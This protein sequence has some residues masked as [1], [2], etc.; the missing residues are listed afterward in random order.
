M[1]ICIIALLS[2]F[3]CGGPGETDNSI[4]DESFMATSSGKA[5]SLYN[6]HPG[7]DKA[8]GILNL[9]NS[10]SLQTLDSSEGV[11]LDVRA[12]ENI[13]E[14]RQDKKIESL[15][16][17]DAISWVS[18]R[19][20][21]KLVDYADA[22]GF[23]ENDGEPKVDIIVSIDRSGSMKDE[24]RS[25]QNSISLLTDHLD[26]HDVNWR[27]GITSVGCSEIQSDKDLSPSFRDLFP[28]R[29]DNSFFP[30]RVCSKQLFNTNSKAINGRLVG[31]DFASKTQKV[32]RRIKQTPN[33]NEEY[34]M[35]MAA[36]ALERALP[37]KSSSTSQIRPDAEVV[38]LTLSDES[39]GLLRFQLK[40][41]TDNLSNRVEPL[42]NEK[43]EEAVG[44]WVNH[45]KNRVSLTAFGIYWPPGQ[46]CD[47]AA[48]VAHGMSYLVDQ[49][50]GL[51]AS[52]CGTK[53]EDVLVE[54]ASKISGIA[55]E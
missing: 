13:V 24:N 47:S 42:D 33:F 48:R 30:N 7:S 18:Q 34:P 23:F 14:A 52:I 54:F 46:S 41:R 43:L 39:D 50:G 37:V 20:F 27:I 11:G 32:V 51:E 12:A 5:D 16:E 10:A 28:N 49:T 38:L 44:P 29:N 1:G 4:K 25:F 45:F 15:H 36:A 55:T 19:A 40:E 9:V 8:E 6:I 35:T 26:D 21:R 53:M 17:L 2:A 31:G 22:N 3:G